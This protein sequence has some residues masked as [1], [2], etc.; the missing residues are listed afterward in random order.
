MRGEDALAFA[1]LLAVVAATEASRSIRRRPARSLFSCPPSSQ[2]ASPRGKVVEGYSNARGDDILL[3]RPSGERYVV[4]PSALQS[5]LDHRFRT[6]VDSR[7][8][9]FHEEFV[10]TARDGTA[11]KRLDELWGLYGTV[12]DSANSKLAT[13]H[14][15]FNSMTAVPPGAAGAPHIVY[16]YADAG[17]MTPD[18]QV[19][20]DYLWAVLNMQNVNTVGPKQISQKQLAK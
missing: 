9:S 16:D 3:V 15:R 20:Q 4:S 8:A 17:G 10:T 7:L 5:Y 2:T 18:G 6:L 13:L 12:V 11:R 14:Q 19:V 1:L